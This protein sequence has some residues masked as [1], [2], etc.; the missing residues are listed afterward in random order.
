MYY[1]N[2][3]EVIGHTPLVKI[4]KLNPNPRVT[5]LAKLEFLN[6]GGSIKD[7]IAV[8]MVKK[9]EKEGKLKPGGTIVEPTSGNTGAGLAMVAAVKGYQSV[10][11]MPDKMSLEKRN[12]LRSYG[13]RVVITPTGVA[14]SDPRS[15][16]CVSDRLAKEAPGGFKPDQ[17]QNSANPD[18]HFE[19]TGPEI[20][21]GTEGKVTHVVIGM[22]TGGTATG[23]GKY[24]KEKNPEIKIIGVDP[25]GSVYMDYFKTKNIPVLFK[26]YKVEGVGE[27]FIP[28]TIDFSVIDDVVVVGDKESFITARRLAR[29]EGILA[30]GSSGLAVAGMRQAVKKIK[31]GMVVVILPDSGRNYLS[32]FYNDEWMRDFGFLESEEESIAPLLNKK[33]HFISID[34]AASPYEAVK[35]MRKYQISQ[36]PVIKDKKVVGILS[37]L[38]LIENLYGKEK[39]PVSVEDI[40][41]RTFIELSETISLSE[42]AH[43]LSEQEMVII[44]DKK[45]KPIDVLT[46]IDFLSNVG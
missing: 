38:I 23:I 45:G 29:E 18:A 12:L 16:Y 35:I 2:I 27:D 5:V 24:L 1:Q 21:E 4:N 14:P 22:G 39:I 46:R 26:T 3:L 31:K 11:V 42:L 19:T 43:A 37:E 30:G 17:Y 8:S 6:P 28:E 15:Y 44:V 34:S 20:W 36:M 33:L 41:N 40:M 10:F 7:R 9:A 13:S 25:V 32:K